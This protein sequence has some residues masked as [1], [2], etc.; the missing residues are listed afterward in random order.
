MSPIAA[1]AGNTG[2]RF[3][4]FARMIGGRGTIEAAM[5]AG[6]GIR[7][8]GRISG[9][10]IAG[11][12]GGGT[13][14]PDEAELPCTLVGG[15]GNS[16]RGNPPSNT[17]SIPSIPRSIV[18]SGYFGK[19]IVGSGWCPSSSSHSMYVSGNSSGSAVHHALMVI[20]AMYG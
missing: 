3:A 4:A 9:G 8:V 14:S 18:M 16:P 11:G 13:R 10:A 12:G 1:L 15:C 5:T 17:T 2:G 20:P 19:M 7:N 6:E